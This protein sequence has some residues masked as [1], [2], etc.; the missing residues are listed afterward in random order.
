MGRLS[1]LSI[2]LFILPIAI[3][4][5]ILIGVETWRVSQG[6]PSLA[7]QDNRLTTEMYCQAEYGVQPDPG[8]Y[9]CEFSPLR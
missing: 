4:L 5:G 2:G 7:T 9:V 6:K 1:F 8:Q 3:T